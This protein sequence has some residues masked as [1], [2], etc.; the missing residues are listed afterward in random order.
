MQEKVEAGAGLETDAALHSK[1]TIPLMKTGLTEKDVAELVQRA[2]DKRSECICEIVDRLAARKTRA[3]ENAARAKAPETQASVS[4]CVAELQGLLNALLKE[5]SF[6]KI[7]HAE[8]PKWGF[9]NSRGSGSVWKLS[10]LIAEAPLDERGIIIH[11]VLLEP[12]N[13]RIGI[14]FEFP[15]SLGNVQQKE[16][17]DFPI[18]PVRLEEELRKLMNAEQLVSAVVNAIHERRITD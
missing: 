9:E 6:L 11:V 10:T 4:A 3:E 1:Q 17:E 18:S 5:E 12:G 15:G 7:L 8:W 13:P 2:C 16:I 14:L